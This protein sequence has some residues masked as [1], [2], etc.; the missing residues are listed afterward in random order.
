MSNQI[1]LA[2]FEPI[3]QSET[4]FLA[5]LRPAMEAAVEA[6]GGSPSSLTITSTRPTKFASGGYTVVKLNE[7]TAFRLKLRGKQQYVSVPTFFADL[8]PA[9]WPQS[10]VAAEP[11]YIRLPVNE[12]RPVSV[13]A[14][15]LVRVAGETVNRYPKEWDCCSRYEECSN[16]RQCV[17]P[18]KAFALSCGYRKILNSGKIYFGA[19]RNV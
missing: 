5:G 9:D 4:D 13:Y 2:G 16:A 15:F 19:N 11:K 17:H 6:N 18:D 3:S 14:D 8:I 12:T 7:F 1:S 10:I